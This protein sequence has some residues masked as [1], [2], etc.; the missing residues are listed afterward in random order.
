MYLRKKAIKHWKWF[1]DNV[2]YVY[3]DFDFIQ[4]VHCGIQH[5]IVAQY[6]LCTFCAVLTSDGIK[7]VS[8][9]LDVLRYIC[10]SCDKWYM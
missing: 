7:V 5:C 3:I 4:Y 9:H 6:S 10:S 8:E 2:G 1:S